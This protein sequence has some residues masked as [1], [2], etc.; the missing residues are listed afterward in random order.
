VGRSG[1]RTHSALNANFI[2]LDRATP[3]WRGNHQN[4]RGIKD[5][6][7]N[8]LLAQAIAAHGGLDR[9]N[10]FNKI[11]TTIVGGGGL[12]PMKGLDLDFS[13]SREMTVT[14]HEERASISRLASRNCA[15]H[16]RPTG[17]RLNHHG[18]CR[19]RTLQSKVFFRRPRYE[20]GVGS[21]SPCVFQRLCNVDLSHLAGL[22]V[23]I[24]SAHRM[25]STFRLW[26]RHDF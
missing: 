6:N 8:D 2:G 18:C 20:H 13:N 23:G 21:A 17:S 12:W 3:P 5:Q 7:M 25:T 1:L 10:K 19:P 11:T 16:S 9:W 15:P 24:G 14:L 26:L 4:N 22:E